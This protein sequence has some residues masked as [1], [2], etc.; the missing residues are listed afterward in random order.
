MKEILSIDNYDY[1][2]LMSGQDYPIRPNAEFHD[3]LKQNKG[4]SFMSVEAKVPKS[5]WWLYATDRYRYYHLNDFNF[6]GKKLI[7]KISK[8]IL[9]KRQFLYPDYQLYGGPGA[10]FCALTRQAAEYI[11]NFMDNNRKARRYAKFTHASDEFWF[12][13]LL[14]NS[15]LKDKVINQPLWYIDWGGVSKHPRILTVLDF[16]TFIGSKL[17]FGRK[18]DIYVDESVLDMLDN[19]LNERKSSRS[20]LAE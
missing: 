16:P 20:L 4:F 17:F 1:V 19:H 7:H 15:P 6:Y 12:Q 8:K 5:N 14:M 18:F 9:P 10:T 13:T 3:Y 2:V 11:V